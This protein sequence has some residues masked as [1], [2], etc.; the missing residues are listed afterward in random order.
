MH[1]VYLAW[2]GAAGEG[3]V[4]WWEG[5]A[6]SSRRWGNGNMGQPPQADSL[7]FTKLNVLHFAKLHPISY[8]S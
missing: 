2:A 7:K 4:E 5:K 3:G 8:I 6:A 1:L